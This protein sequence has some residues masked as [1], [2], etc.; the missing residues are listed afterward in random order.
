MVLKIKP[1][2][3][4]AHPIT[5][6][7]DFELELIRALSLKSPI[8]E[9]EYKAISAEKLLDKIYDLTLNLYK[10]KTEAIREQAWPVIKDVYENQQGYENIVVPISDGARVFQV[11]ANMEESYKTEGAEVV[12]SF[13]KII[14]LASIDDV[15]KEHLR[16][17]DDL[18][19]SVQNASYEQKDPL[20]IYKFEAFELFKKVVDKLNKD[21][22]SSLMKAHLFLKE[23]QQV[24][25]NIAPARL[26]LD[27]LKT[28][29]E[30]S[31]SGQQKEAKKAQPVRVEKKVGRNEPCPCGSGKK[32]KNCHGKNQ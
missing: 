6:F 25:A 3:D 5:E 20:L 4:A 11:T 7:A 30:E 26:N 19:Q 1:P 31:P 17:M 8:D 24:Q 16:E 14:M 23:A 9:A 18:K 29:R 10:R 12:K 32:Y 21:V 27:A 22:V 28:G 15:W 13:E 2:K